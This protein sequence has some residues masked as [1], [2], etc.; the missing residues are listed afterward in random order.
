MTLPLLAG[1]GGKIICA[2]CVPVAQAQDLVVDQTLYWRVVTDADEAAE[3][4]SPRTAPQPLFWTSQRGKGRVFAC[5]PGH[6]NW[7]FDD[8]YFRILLLRGMAWAAGE[9]PYRFDGL[10]LR[11]AAVA[12]PK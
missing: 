4:G 7:T 2:A 10:V 9:P 1:A 3:K 11:G 8:P 12:E 5:V 6:F